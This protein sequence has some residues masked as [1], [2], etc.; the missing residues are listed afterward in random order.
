MIIIDKVSHREI[1]ASEDM[2]FFKNDFYFKKCVM[3]PGE[4]EIDYKEVPEAEAAYFFQQNDK[5]APE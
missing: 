1:Q 5:Q 3:L 2:Y 4:T